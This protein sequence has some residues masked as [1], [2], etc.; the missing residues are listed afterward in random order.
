MPRLPARAGAVGSSTGGGAGR[1]SG[2]MASSATSDAGAGDAGSWEDVF[3]PDEP[4]PVKK[5][6]KGVQAVRVSA[7][8]CYLRMGFAFNHVTFRKLLTNLQQLE[9]NV[10]TCASTV[11]RCFWRCCR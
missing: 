8:R 4:E 6:R 5:F 9:A 3:G 10:R 11:L 7:A 1:P 2:G